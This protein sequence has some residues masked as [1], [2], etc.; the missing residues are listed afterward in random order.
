MTGGDTSLEA[1]ANYTGH[2]GPSAAGHLILA[3][4]PARFGQDRFLARIEKLFEAMLADDGVRLPGDRRLGN[5][6]TTPTTGVQ[7]PKALHDQ[8]SAIAAGS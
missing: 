6:A 3:M 7:I 8:V 1:E 4:D 5:R 2:G